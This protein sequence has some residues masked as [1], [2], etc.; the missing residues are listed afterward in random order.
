MSW[1]GPFCISNFPSFKIH[2]AKFFLAPL[3]HEPVRKYRA[4]NQLE[5]KQF[6]FYDKHFNQSKGFG[7]IQRNIWWSMYSG[8]WYTRPTLTTRKAGIKNP[9]SMTEF[10]TDK[11]RRKF[12]KDFRP[13]SDRNIEK[14]NRICQGFV[15][16]IQLSEICRKFLTC[17]R[18][19]F[20][21]KIN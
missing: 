12:S 14:Y 15:S 20:K 18:R 11:M 2:S 21:N 4:S 8:S 13:I 3:E 10:A 5:N 9:A 6:Q 1:F 16:E 19:S 7:G 17:L